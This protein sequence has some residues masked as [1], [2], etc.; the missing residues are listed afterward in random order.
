M[1]K[2]LQMKTAI[3]IFLNKIT[4]VS[5]TGYKHVSNEIEQVE[6]QRE[7]LKL[8]LEQDELIKECLN[9]EQYVESIKLKIKKLRNIVLE[10]SV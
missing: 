2:T 5:S 8:Q 4:N 1:L 7:N 9:I 3:L 10:R 6:P